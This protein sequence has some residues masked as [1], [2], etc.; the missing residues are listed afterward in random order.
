MSY[1]EIGL[2]E[3]AS[4]SWIAFVWDQDT[5]VEGETQAEALR[6]LADELEEDEP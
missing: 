6:G 3:Q 4:G 1:E 5:E 2:Q